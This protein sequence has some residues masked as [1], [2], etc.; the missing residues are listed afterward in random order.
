[1]HEEK[2]EG[3]STKCQF[4][5]NCG[6]IPSNLSHCPNLKNLS[7][8]NNL[9]E[10]EIP[11]EFGFHHKLQILSASGN[12]LTGG[13]PP[14]LG[15]SLS[16]TVVYLGNNDLT[17][18]IPPFLAN[19][20]S[21]VFVD[22]SQ[23]S[24]TGEI[25]HSFFNSST[26]QAI[27]L[28]ENGLTGGIPS[29]PIIR[30]SPLFFLAL[31][32]N[33]LSGSIPPSLGNLSN[34][35]GLYLFENR[36]EGSIPESLGKIPGL[37]VLDLS[38]NNLYGRMPPTLYNLSSLAYL[39]VGANRLFGT[40]P[41]D[42]GVTLQNL[43]SLVMQKSLFQGHIPA[44]LYNASQIQL[45]DLSMNSFKG[46]LSSSVGS[47]KNLVELNLGENQLQGNVWSVLSSLTNCSFLERLYLHD[48][49]LEGNLPA[50]VGNL[51][52]Q[53]E[54]LVVEGNQIS[55]TIPVEIGNLANLTVLSMDKNLLT[56]SIPP[57][58]GRLQKLI[59]LGMSGNKF[60]G[61]IPSSI[62]NL[63]QLN[64]LYMQENELSDNIPASF[65]DCRNLNI[66]NLSNNAL[67]GP[68]PKELVALSSLTRALDLSHNILTGSIPM[69]VGSSIN[70]DCLNVSNNRLSGEI[71]RTLGT[72]QHL[73]YLR[74]EGNF[75]QGN[76]PQSF[77]NLRGLSELDLSRNNL[78]GRIPEFF[79][80][81]SSLQY[82]NLSF[83]D[84]EG[85]VPKDGVFDNS[86]ETVVVLGNKRLCGGDAKLRLPP[87][88]IQASERNLFKIIIIIIASV[89]IA[90]FFLCFLLIR[91]QLRKR[92]ERSTSVP[93][94][95]D[96]YRI[97][98][99][100]DLL[101]ATDGFSSANL[102]GTGNSGSVYKGKLG[103]EEK[104]VAVKVFNIHQVGALK[105]FK[106][107][108]EIIRNV[109][110]SNLVRIITSCS[111]IDSTGNDFK[112]LIFEYMPNGSLDEWLHPKAQECHRTRTLDLTQRLNIALDVASALCYLHHNVEVPAIHCDL[113]PSNVLLDNDMTAH[114]GDFGLSR[115]LPTSGSTT[116][117]NSASLMGI[118]GTIGYVAPEYAM[119]SQISTQ[120]DVYSYGILLLEMLTGMKPTNSMFKDGLNLHKFV[121]MAFPER[122]MVILDPQILQN[123]Q[124]EEF[125]SN[126]RNENFGRMQLRRCIISLT[127]IGLLCSKE[128]PKE[129]PR[130][131][132]VADE[133]HAVKEMLSKVEI[134]EGG[135][136]V[137]PE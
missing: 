103:C 61:P 31:S 35:L 99:Y 124:S 54:R 19:S 55:G 136:A 92:R 68:I 56:G 53:L 7:L 104:F 117:K 33:S 62:G 84:L 118:K 122:A 76:I 112:A 96:K 114:V 131:R 45:L 71:P 18:G 24:L 57:T 60:S 63:T 113:K 105:S 89:I 10:G 108:C 28:F 98:S 65:G 67:V 109:R 126:I 119:G 44:S 95:E 91:L 79:G 15:S 11:K 22:L 116:S 130:M 21:L 16:L 115:F 47:L 20:S 23:N 129:R 90:I 137:L 26:L 81:F 3:S 27:N 14:L 2:G 87:C 13:I 49:K 74:M 69:E 32:I 77:I 40:L 101:K 97:I 51:S 64:E 72:C 107:E 75:F 106:A 8:K 94:Q 25:P 41:P 29:F 100:T 12:H 127:R 121:N 36:L 83:N 88:S 39:G 38:I 132:D 1:M 111:S 58:I 70:L 4:L 78:S 123:D 59:L 102:V 128:S 134:I 50:S 120:G 17:G 93:S 43:Q 30:A 42:I 82:L 80:S 110:H 9:L 52:T 133:V 48:N 135:A 34:L 85:E 6:E 5:R 125:N 73:E 66:L 46:L 86:S 37:E